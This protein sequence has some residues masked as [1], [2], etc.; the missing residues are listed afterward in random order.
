MTR[1]QWSVR[2]KLWTNWSRRISFLGA[3]DNFESQVS[4]EK[5]G[6]NLGHLALGLGGQPVSKAVIFDFDGVIADTE[7][8]QLK[9]YNRLLAELDK[10]Q[11]SEQAFISDWLGQPTSQI[12]AD[13]KHDFSIPNQPKNLAVRKENIYQE[14]VRSELLAPRPGLVD[15]LSAL[16]VHGWRM[17]I[18][19][20]SPATTIRRLLSVFGIE[21]YF[22]KV[23]SSENLVRGKPAPDIYELAA[24][25]LGVGEDS[26]AVIED[27]PPGLLSAKAAGL[28]CVVVP[29]RFTKDLEF[30]GS[31]LRVE[32]L[33]E[34]THG[35]L[36]SLVKSNIV[37]VPKSVTGYCERDTQRD[38]RKSV[39]R[40]D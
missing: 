30:E 2:Q 27:S 12:L 17:A 5:R 19:S 24:H 32:E 23:L 7:P 31:D 29:T 18:A 35:R 38:S 40:Q 39:G 9:A 11:L 21:K 4:A 33:T 1:C 25:L 13:L 28:R 14:L 10:P 37:Y 34:V 3:L 8:L 26:I 22:E 36:L 16:K 20:S 15:L 6:A